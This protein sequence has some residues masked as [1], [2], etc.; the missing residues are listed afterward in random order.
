MKLKNLLIA[1]FSILLVLFFKT[2]IVYA[3]DITYKTE[4]YTSTN[5]SIYVNG[6]DNNLEDGYNYY[7]YITQDNTI[8][9]ETFLSNARY[10]KYDALSYDKEKKCFYKKTSS[11]FGIFEKTGD[12]YAYIAKGNISETGIAGTTDSFTFVDGPTKLERPSLLPNGQR[13][14]VYYNENSISYYI[15]QYEHYTKLYG[16]DR[17]IEFYLGKIEDE[18]LLIK[19]SDNTSDA[20][21]T[22]YNYAKENNTYL[23]SG[24]FETTSTGIV[25]YNILQDFSGLEKGEN[26]FVYYKLDNEN[27]LYVEMDDVQAYTVN[28]SGFLD[29]FSKYNAKESNSKQ[30][31][32]LQNI[33]ES[34]DLSEENSIIS[35]TKKD[36]DSTNTIDKLPYT[37]VS[38]KIFLILGLCFIILSFTYLKYEKYKNL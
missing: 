2:N 33:E 7:I 31:E 13:I 15:K 27:G 24:S 4:F 1:L 30:E 18:S 3:N 23:Y 32:E 12:Y 19:L 35:K 6:L 5:T 22:L 34:E 20:Y 16:T 17:K 28:S 29:K 36:K 11:Y 14:K 26:Y 9:E 8:D 10:A 38:I 37:G 21:D 25:D